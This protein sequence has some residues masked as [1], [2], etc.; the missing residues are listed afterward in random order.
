MV[1]PVVRPLYS[2]PAKPCPRIYKPCSTLARA[3]PPKKKTKQQQQKNKK[4]KEKWP[5]YPLGLAKMN[6]PQ[7]C[8][9]LQAEPLVPSRNP[10]TR[11]IANRRPSL[12]SLQAALSM[13]Q[14]KPPSIIFHHLLAFEVN[15]SLRPSPPTIQ[16]PL[17]CRST[18]GLSFC[19]LGAFAHHISGGVFGVLFSNHLRLPHENSRAPGA[20]PIA[21]G[22]CL[23]PQ[24]RGRGDKHNASLVSPTT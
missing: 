23:E 14:R 22:V 13:Q 16:P 12:A 7:T 6:T 24:I 4:K 17:A 21:G 10:Q 9:L 11:M 5:W 2:E 1:G 8:H 3:P 15:L 18:L 20:R 19:I